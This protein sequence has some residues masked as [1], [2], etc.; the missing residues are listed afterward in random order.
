MEDD[1]VVVTPL[2]ESRKILAGSG[3]V[4]IVELDDD[5]TLRVVRRSLFE[6]WISR[7]FTI[8]VSST[9]SVAILVVRAPNFTLPWPCA[10]PLS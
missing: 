10:T 5:G 3:S 7:I 1:I 9:T 2:S 4:V 8:V 6:F